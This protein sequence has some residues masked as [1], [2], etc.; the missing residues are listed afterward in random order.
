[1]FLVPKSFKMHVKQSMFLVPKI[2][3]FLAANNIDAG[4]YLK[5]YF[6]IQLLFL[7][8]NINV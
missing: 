4:T 5:L 7:R 1:M 6:I 2:Y 3:L 8:E